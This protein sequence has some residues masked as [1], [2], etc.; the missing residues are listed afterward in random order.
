MKGPL[1]VVTVVILVKNKENSMTYQDYNYRSNCLTVNFDWLLTP[2][3]PGSFASRRR[4]LEL[5]Q[6]LEGIGGLTMARSKLRGQKSRNVFHIASQKTFKT[7][8]KAK[9]VTTNLKKVNIVN[10]EKVHRMNKAF[11]DIQ[12]E[13]AHFSKGL[14]LEPVQKQVIP[15]QCPEN[16]PVN[17]D[18][19]TRLMA[20][21]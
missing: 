2:E 16:E 6:P 1:M 13:L 11:I 14:S 4:P 18:E 12:K 10:A 9:P 20:Q 7:K 21:L 3:L 5:E 19:A 17:V 8:N 15:Q